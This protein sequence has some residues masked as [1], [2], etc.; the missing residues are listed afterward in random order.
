MVCSCLWNWWE[1]VLIV[2]GGWSYAMFAGLFL[3]AWLLGERRSAQRFRALWTRHRAG[4]RSVWPDNLLTNSGQERDSRR[5]IR[6]DAADQPREI[7]HE[8]AKR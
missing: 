5:E 3:W 8:P 7:D 1:W 2:T 6:D 4:N